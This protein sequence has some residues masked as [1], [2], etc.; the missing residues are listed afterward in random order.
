MFMVWHVVKHRDFTFTF[1]FNL[2]Q[3]DEFMKLDVTFIS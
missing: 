2:F 1:T 3:N